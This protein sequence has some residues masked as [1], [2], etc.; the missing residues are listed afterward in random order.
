M[1]QVISVIERPV[2]AKGLRKEAFPNEKRVRKYIFDEEYASL[3]LLSSLVPFSHR[4][5]TLLYPGC[6]SDILLPLIYLGHLFPQ[7]EN[8]HYIFIDIQPCLGLIK[9]ILDDVGVSFKEKKN[10]ID[11]Y[12]KGK[13]IQVDFIRQDVFSALPTL[14]EFDIYFE[15]A[16]RIM[17][18][19]CAQYEPFIISKLKKNGVLISD[20]GFSQFPLERLPVDQRLGA[21]G[22]MIIGKKK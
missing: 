7:V 3:G 8:V 15:R 22:E 1:G 14:P 17:K 2:T 18:D 19:S 21:Y 12:W 16:F 11:F 20:S 10:S 13:L 9:T 6:G 4:Q 5:A